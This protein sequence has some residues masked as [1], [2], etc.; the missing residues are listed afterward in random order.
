MKTQFLDLQST[1]SQKVLVTS[2]QFI[3]LVLLSYVKCQRVFQ[4]FIHLPL[5][6][7]PPLYKAPD[8]VLI[9]SAQICSWKGRS[10]AEPAC[11]A[12]YNRHKTRGLW[13]TWLT[14]Q[15]FLAVMLC[16]IVIQWWV[17]SFHTDRTLAFSSGKPKSEKE[18]KVLIT[19][20][21]HFCSHCIRLFLPWLIILSLIMGI[22]FISLNVNN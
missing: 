19:V 20:L 2:F 21:V 12:T 9:L 14:C 17:W 1:L 16:G 13:T 18:L 5:G 6:L 11:P 10:L 3:D 4:C 7:W 22:V 15:Q 8:T